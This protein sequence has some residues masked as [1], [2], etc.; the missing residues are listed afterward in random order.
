V[1]GLCRRADPLC[2]CGRNPKTRQQGERGSY[3]DGKGGAGLD[4]GSARGFVAIWLV[5]HELSICLVAV[6]RCDLRPP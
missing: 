6:V 2:R 1:I 4:A 5:I 3:S